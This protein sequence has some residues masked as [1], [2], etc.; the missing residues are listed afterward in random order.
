ML[1]GKQRPWETGVEV[2]AAGDM[3]KAQMCLGLTWFTGINRTWKNPK[4]W[5]FCLESFAGSPEINNAFPWR[6]QK[7]ALNKTEGAS[8]FPCC[9]PGFEFSEK[10]IELDVEKDAISL[11]EQLKSL[12][13]PRP[14]H[15]H[16]WE[17]GG[18][19]LGSFVRGLETEAPWSCQMRPLT[20]AGFAF[21][22]IPTQRSGYAIGFVSNPGLDLFPLPQQK[23]MN[24]FFLFYF[25]LLWFSICRAPCNL[26]TTSSWHGKYS[27]LEMHPEH[28]A[29]HS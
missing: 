19:C 7:K 28:G 26:G 15:N 11:F 18:T 25:S 6:F 29:C 5:I 20:R 14:C 21:C 2:E 8:N 1:P 10:P 3:D 4:L 17:H 12:S 24:Y 22:F 23:L 9:W 13:H 27:D 16:S